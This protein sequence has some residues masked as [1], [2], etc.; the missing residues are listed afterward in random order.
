MLDL[1]AVLG[2][3]RAMERRQETLHTCRSSLQARYATSPRPAS[4]ASSRCGIGIYRQG[5]CR[6]SRRQARRWRRSF[7]L[8]C[9]RGRR[10]G[11]PFTPWAPSILFRS[12]HV[13]PRFLAIALTCPLQ[14]TQMARAGL[15]ALYIS[16]WACSRYETCFSKRSALDAQLTISLVFSVLTTGSNDLG[17]D[18]A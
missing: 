13:H 7:G 11:S 16:G 15:E 1:A 12:A 10:K 18:L 6:P 5:R 9:R 2:D 14:V 8:C 17:P 3:G 4:I